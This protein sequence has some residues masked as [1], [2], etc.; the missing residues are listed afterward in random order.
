LCCAKNAVFLGDL[1]KSA[2][3]DL[4][5]IIER[6]PQGAETQLGRLFNTGVDLS[7]GQWQRLTVARALC[8]RAPVLLLD[9]PTAFVDR[10]TAT[11]LTG[12]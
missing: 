7:L 10:D 2:I 5:D 9:E 1:R 4:D 8:K 3:A 12:C 11:R 6:L